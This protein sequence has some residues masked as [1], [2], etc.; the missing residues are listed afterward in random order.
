[1]Q[2]VSQVMSRNAR[3]VAPG[4]SLQRAAQLM[5]ELNV[6]ALPVCEGERLVGMVTDRD[7]AVRG[8]AA[9]KAP[10]SSHVDEVMTADVRWCYEDQALDE[11]MAQMGD[12]QIRRVPVVSHDDQHR[13]LGI[14]S[15]A[16]LATRSDNRWDVEDVVEMV[17]SPSDA[18]SEPAAHAGTGDDRGMPVV[19]EAGVDPA[20]G[21]RG[22]DDTRAPTGKN[23]AGVPEALTGLD[24]RSPGGKLEEVGVTG[25]PRIDNTGEPLRNAGSDDPADNAS[26]ERDV[27]G[28]K[29]PSTPSNA[30]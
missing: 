15:L 5:G 1:M 13:L 10:Q 2:T 8:I 14:V 22:G 27:D 3:F 11:V 17:S 6:G 4:E 28:R 25:Q 21:P 29:P 23:A 24:Q 19:H 9:G 18:P 26:L 12:N 30:V 16:D 7:I 20:A